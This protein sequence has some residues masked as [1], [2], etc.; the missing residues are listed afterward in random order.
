MF[1]YM[2]DARLDELRFL[3]RLERERVVTI[4]HRKPWD[5]SEVRIA[6]QL[7]AAGIVNDAT[8]V[9][10]RDHEFRADRGM[11]IIPYRNRIAFEQWEAIGLLHEA[12]EVRIQATHAAAVRRAE[13]EQSVQRGRLRDATGILFDGRYA[14]RDLQIALWSASKD[15]PV[16]VA[17]LD[18]NGLKQINDTMGHS[19]GTEAIQSF[20]EVIA[21]VVAETG[22]AYRVGGDEVLI[23]L[24]KT[25]VSKGAEL[26]RIILRG[27]SGR[28][29]GTGDRV[30]RLS[31]V[32]GVTTVIDPNKPVD[33]VTRRADSIQYRAKE[34]SKAKPPT[35]FGALAVEDL[36]PEEFPNTAEE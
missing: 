16:T 22:D 14:S 27:V 26:L 13:L 12:Q 36:A 31:A 33:E 24:P 1:R 23:V 9:S 32:A 6:I 28:R 5:D 29:V 20:F 19:A 17:Y 25:A 35:R 21:S 15:A 34:A 3:A 10:S 8:V 4:S 30:V 18:M 7:L 11:G 2:G